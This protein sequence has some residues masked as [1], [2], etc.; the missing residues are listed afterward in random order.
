MKIIAH[1]LISA[2][3]IWVA[4]YLLSGVNISSV[5]TLVVLV[6][7]FGIVNITIRPILKLIT[8]P[9]TII[10]LGLFSV[11]L[12]AFLVLLV[13]KVVPG[14]TVDG[15]LTAVYFSIILSL[16]HLVLKPFE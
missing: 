3:A 2:L 15:F 12:N 4:D 13:A 14:F 9:L 11:V 1:F 7:V 8:L 6:I 5:Q 16:V 10:T